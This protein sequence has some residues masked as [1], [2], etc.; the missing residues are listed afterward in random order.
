[1]RLWIVGGG[2]GGHVYPAL[3][4]AEALPGVAPDAELTW[5]GTL[6]GM[7]G[8]LVRR[9]GYSFVGIPGGGLHGVALLNAIRNG[10]LLVRGTWEA[11]KH[12][13]RE[14][15][16]AVLTTGGYVSGP[17]IMAARLHGVPILVFVPDIEPAQSVKAVARVA[18]RVA[19]TVEDSLR[20]VSREKAVVTGYPLGERITRWTRAEG[21]AALGVD[22][23]APMLFV[24]G[25]SRGARSINRAVMQNIGALAEAAHVVHV[26]GTL[27]WP[28]V[29]SVQKALPAVVRSRYHV[30][31][32]LH[33]RMGGALAAADL[34]VSRA[35]ASILG[36][37][38]YFG[39]PS[40]LVPY[41]YAWRYQRVNAGWLEDRGAAVIVEDEVLPGDIV[42][43]VTGLLADRE[44][45]G[46][47]ADASRKLARP[48][49]AVEIAQLFL[50]LGQG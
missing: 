46:R 19:I 29:E 31:P 14:R 41:P 17:V 11:V 25:G 21:R 34:V 42:P 33:E 49:A 22:E 6:D 20:Y 38:P 50:E 28:E 8:D 7:E 47:M 35:G 15:P 3:A 4:V 1:M 9:E 48:R 36:E 32:Y 2:T 37:F 43:V 45:L 30:V 10:W 40:V 44:R 26:S 5:I 24:F 16:A 39:L 13:R 27:D 12:V 23:N 18:G